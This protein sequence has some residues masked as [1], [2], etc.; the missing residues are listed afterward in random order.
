MPDPITLGVLGG[1]A[2]TEGIKFLYDQAGAL[3]QA[4]RERRNAAREAEREPSVAEPLDVPISAGD[5]LD[6]AMSS[7]RADAG[8]VAQNENLMDDLQA[9]IGRYASGDREVPDTDDVLAGRLAELRG[10]LEAAYGQRLTF[11]G[12]QRDPTGTRVSVE[13]VVEEVG[14]RLVGIGELS[15]NTQVEVR[16]RIK[17][18]ASGGEATGID[19]VRG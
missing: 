2:A 14:G 9:L 15:G 13:Q 1:L 3:L 5:V 11:K 8:V 18:V 16:Q 7:A 10:L 12:E 17:T 4:W 6:S 19:S